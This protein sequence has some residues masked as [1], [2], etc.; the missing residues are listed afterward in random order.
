[1][2]MPDWFTVNTWPPYVM[3][4][5]LA[6]PELKSGAQKTVREK[7]PSPLTPFT[8]SQLE[9]LDAVST[10]SAGLTVAANDPENAP[11]LATTL[12]LAGVRTTATVAPSWFKVTEVAPMVT[13]PLRPA[14]EALAVTV[15]WTVVPLTPAVTKA[16]CDETVNGHMVGAGVTAML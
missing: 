14:A 3:C 10:A 16:A 4:P 2:Q 5:T 8:R 11:G 15:T 7:L 9:S 6:G 13:V 12:A 1:M